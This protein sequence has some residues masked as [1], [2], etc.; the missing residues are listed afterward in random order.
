MR[1]AHG[2]NGW[3]SEATTTP[4]E[5]NGDDRPSILPPCLCQTRHPTC[6]DARELDVGDLDLLVAPGIA[7]LLCTQAGQHGNQC[8]RTHV[9]DAHPYIGASPY[10]GQLH[11]TDTT[12][13]LA[14]R[15]RACRAPPSKGR[16]N[17]YSAT[18]LCYTLHT[19]GPS[20]PPTYESNHTCCLPSRMP[21]PQLPASSTRHVTA[22]ASPN[23]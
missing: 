18:P 13:T 12:C 4:A 19:R 7:N 1:A 3:L 15:A 16:N 5:P 23:P 14:P 2:S 6:S 9:S 8:V 20:S 17:A 11:R 21:M 10:W 22:L